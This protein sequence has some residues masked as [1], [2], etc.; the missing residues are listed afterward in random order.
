MLQ[1]S[2]DTS[3]INEQKQNP[4]ANRND[5]STLNENDNDNDNDSNN[6]DAMQ[7]LHGDDDEKN[8]I[9]ERL[10]NVNLNNNLNS[11]LD[12]AESVKTRPLIEEI[13]PKDA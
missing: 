6:E 2:I 8:T 7:Q 10:M 9:V 5:E 12:A 11:N 3:T 1:L 13:D 4:S